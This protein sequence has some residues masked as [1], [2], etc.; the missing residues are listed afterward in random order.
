MRGPFDGMR[1][2]WKES[3]GNGNGGGNGHTEAPISLRRKPPTMPAK[4][5]P[6]EPPW[7]A[8]LDREGIPRTLH[9][10]ATS[11]G[12]LVDQA[13]DR[14]GDLPALIYNNSRLSYA[15]LVRR[16]NRMAGGLSRLGV[17]RGDRI[18]LALPNCPEYVFAFFAA[19]KLGAV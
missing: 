17:R 8:Q 13:A 18:V 2:W 4:A 6:P 10:P 5:P 19:Q 1:R 12:R 3:N 7:L 11:L 14:F 9:Y 16:I 15:E